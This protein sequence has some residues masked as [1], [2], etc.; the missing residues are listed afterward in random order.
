LVS[1]AIVD[2]CEKKIPTG[3]QSGIKAVNMADP[4]DRAV[5][6]AHL[7][8]ELPSF[9]KLGCAKFPAPFDAATAAAPADKARVL[10]TGCDYGKLG[11][12]S[13]A[14][15]ATALN[16][17]PGHAILAAPLYKWLIDNGVAVDAA[18]KIIRAM[19]GL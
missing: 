8:L 12:M 13:Q 18:R 5:M 3:V 9:S 4:V 17:A 11:L 6:A 19:A 14:E 2:A 15:L 1:R 10:Y 16:R 7:V